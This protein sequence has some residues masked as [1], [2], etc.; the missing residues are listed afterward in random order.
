LLAEN[1]IKKVK[2]D[3]ETYKSKQQAQAQARA[4]QSAQQRHTPNP[5]ITP[6]P[7]QYNVMYPGYPYYGYPQYAY[8]GMAGAYMGQVPQ[9]MDGYGGYTNIPGVQ[10]EYLAA[11]PQLQPDQKVQSPTSAATASISADAVDT[12]RRFQE[13]PP[14][15][16]QKQNSEKEQSESSTYAVSQVTAIGP[17]TPSAEDIAATSYSLPEIPQ[18]KGKLDKVK[19]KDEQENS[20]L[21]LVDYD[22]NTRENSSDDKNKSKLGSVSQRPFWAVP[23]SKEGDMGVLNEVFPEKK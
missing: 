11:Q 16:K 7:Q 10:P 1:L 17:K 19:Q 20:S 2:A 8:Y 4:T 6:H 22:P 9:G 14:A 23:K 13:F 18:S 12:A 21:K 5:N 3:Y 15:K